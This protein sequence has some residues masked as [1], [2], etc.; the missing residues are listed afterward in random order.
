MA[1]THRDT[2]VVRAAAATGARRACT[3]SGPGSHPNRLSAGLRTES[4]DH[5][6]EVPSA[7][8]LALLS[9]AASTIVNESDGT[10]TVEVVRVGGSAGTVTVEVE[11]GSDIRRVL[12]DVKSRVDAINTFPADTEKPVINLRQ[13]RFGVI[14]VVVAGDYSEDEI[15]YDKPVKNGP[16]NLGFDYS[17]L[18]PG[19]LDM[20]PYV[21]LENGLAT[22]IPDSISPKVD[23]PAYTRRGEIAPDFTHQTALD[24][25]TSKAVNY[26]NEQAKMDDPFML[27]FPL[28][29]PHKP[30]LAAERFEG[31]S[32][33]GPYGDLVMQ[34]DWTVGQVLK[35]LQE[36][37]IEDNTLVIYTSDNGSYMFRID[38]EKPDHTDLESVQGYHANRRQSNFIWRGTK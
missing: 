14:D 8:S 13:R 32:G 10:A 22:A 33:Y 31:K 34:V 11:R 28:T 21:Y 35:A 23:F 37:G 38:E 9:T 3:R 18:V 20:S 30:A 36:N 16:N 2:E 17:F 29:G 27:Y 12:D 24:K 7:F 6:A 4:A 26:I 25:L 5:R 1:Y 15:D 19:S